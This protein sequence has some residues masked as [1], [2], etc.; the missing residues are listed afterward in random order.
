MQLLNT[1]SNMAD[2]FEC[3]LDTDITYY[4]ASSDEVVTTES[5]YTVNDAINRKLNKAHLCLCG[6]RVEADLDGSYIITVV[7]A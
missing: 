2:G 5:G 1:I 6:T 3:F 4:R 7:E